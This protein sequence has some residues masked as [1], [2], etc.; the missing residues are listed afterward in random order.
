MA[1]TKRGTK[2]EAVGQP[3]LTTVVKHRGAGN[4]AARRAEADRIY[5]QEMEEA[6]FKRLLD[7]FDEHILGTPLQTVVPSAAMEPESEEEEFPE[8][9]QDRIN[10]GETHFICTGTC[11]RNFHYEDTN[12][13]GQC[14]RC[15]AGFF[16]AD[17]T[18]SEA[19]AYFAADWVKRPSPVVVID[20]TEDS[21]EEDQSGFSLTV[22]QAA[23]YQSPAPLRCPGCCRLWCRM[24][25]QCH[26]VI[27]L[28]ESI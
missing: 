8:T 28:S 11:G 15:E 20:L 5:F 24:R 27:D 16:L 25:G 18:A 2:R 12:G 21:D 26:T 23:P 10:D 4:L 22:L 7:Q 9:L 17:A 3:L 19:D 6:A 13:E 1:K 14:G